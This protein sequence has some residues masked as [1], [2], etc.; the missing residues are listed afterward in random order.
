MTSVNRDQVALRAMD[1]ILRHFDFA[2]FSQDTSRVAMWA[3]DIADAM[4][5]ESVRYDHP[6]ADKGNLVT[7][8]V[9][10][11][12]NDKESNAAREK[13]M[14]FARKEFPRYMVTV[15][16]YNHKGNPTCTS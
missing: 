5:R 11:F 1:A 9:H 3:Y 4:V 13:L 16:V 8:H 6:D 14:S 2:T 15:G 7:L 12:A 10:S